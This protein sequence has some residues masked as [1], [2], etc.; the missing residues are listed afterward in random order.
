[1]RKAGNRSISTGNVAIDTT[2][3]CLGTTTPVLIRKL[4][5]LALTRATLRELSTDCCSVVCCCAF[6]DTR[7]D[8]LWAAAPW[9]CA[10]PLV[11]PWVTFCPWVPVVAPCPCC[12]V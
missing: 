1:S 3:I 12:V 4:I 2:E 10:G 5:E 6:T 7:P 9:L 11:C 8:L